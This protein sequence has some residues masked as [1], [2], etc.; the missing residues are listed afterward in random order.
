MSDCLYVL[1]LIFSFMT[2]S[3]CL[4]HI[5]LFYGHILYVSLTLHAYLGMAQPIPLDGFYS[6]YPHTPGLDLWALLP[7]VVGGRRDGAADVWYF[8]SAAVWNT[9]VPPHL[10]Y[11]PI[12]AVSPRKQLLPR[13]LHRTRF[14]R[15]SDSCC[16]SNRLR[17][18]ERHVAAGS[19]AYRR[20]APFRARCVSR[21]ATAYGTL[22]LRAPA[23]LAR[24]PPA[25]L[26]STPHGGGM[27]VPKPVGILLF[28]LVGPS[29]TSLYSSS[30]FPYPKLR[31]PARAHTYPTWFCRSP[32]DSFAAAY[33]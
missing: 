22:A 8:A 24:C 6:C 13:L 28:L 32:V 3:S 16:V 25:S 1:S 10:L 18:H 29:L 33:L 19:P 21:A 5:T 26:V 30:C 4:S 12:P 31:A 27:D 20:H 15:I 9:A 14:A 7:A 17:A 2:N 23:C 11:T